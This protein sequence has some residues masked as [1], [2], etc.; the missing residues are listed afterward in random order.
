MA[1]IQFFGKS[2]GKEEPV[3]YTVMNYKIGA[4]LGKLIYTSLEVFSYL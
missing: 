4:Q 3:D 1:L 2:H